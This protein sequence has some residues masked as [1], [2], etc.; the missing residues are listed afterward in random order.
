M[1]ETSRFAA[2]RISTWR[3]AALVLPVLAMLSMAGAADAGDGD[4]GF[5]REGEVD[6][7]GW[8]GIANQ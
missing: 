3:R 2:G 1:N 7:I 6:P 4:A 8:T 5:D